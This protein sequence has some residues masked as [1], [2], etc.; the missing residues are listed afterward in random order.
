MTQTNTE[1]AGSARFFSS[2]LVFHGTSNRL[3]PREVHSRSFRGNWLPK[4]L[5]PGAPRGVNP[6][7]IRRAL[8]GYVDLLMNNR[9]AFVEIK[10]KQGMSRASSSILAITAAALHLSP[11]M[12]LHSFILLLR[13]PNRL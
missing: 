11:G 4:R 2:L 3:W 10:A 8:V 7:S 13:K 1:I 5:S 9:R 12:L 6:L